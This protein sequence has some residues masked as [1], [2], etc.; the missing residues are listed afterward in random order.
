MLTLPAW[1]TFYLIRQLGARF[2]VPVGASDFH[3]SGDS[4]TLTFTRLQRQAIGRGH[5]VGRRLRPWRVSSPIAL[6]I[7]ALAV[8]ATEGGKRD[9]VEHTWCWGHAS[10]HWLS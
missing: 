8:A 2:A 7:R 3:W 1:Q 10:G 4:N 6:P 9:P 5:R